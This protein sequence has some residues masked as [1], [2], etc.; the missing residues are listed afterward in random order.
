MEA[1]HRLWKDPC[2]AKMDEKPLDSSA[3]HHSRSLLS[4]DIM[5]NHRSVFVLPDN[6]GTFA[7]QAE[8]GPTAFGTDFRPGLNQYQITNGDHC[9][10]IASSSWI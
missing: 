5:T 10:S 2:F 9:V 1:L 7:A 6:E 4:T 3:I 8:G